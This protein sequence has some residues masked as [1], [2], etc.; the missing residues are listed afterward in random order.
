LE[1]QLQQIPEIEE[2]AI[3]ASLFDF[4]GASPETYDW[5]ERPQDVEPI[6]MKHILFKE[7]VGKLYEFKLVAGE[8]LNE[9]DSKDCIMI[10][11]S[12]AKI[13]GWKDPAGKQLV[14]VNRYFP[15][16]PDYRNYIVKGVIKDIHC[17]SF[18]GPADPIIFR[19]KSLP[20]AESVLFRY[21]EGTWNTCKDKIEQLF[22][23]KY[24]D[25]N[26]LSVRKEEFNYAKYLKSENTLL[27][28]L[29]LISLVCLTVC[30][31]GFVS[32][33]SLTCE[34]RRKEIAIR[35]INGATIKDILDIFFK[36]YLTLFI[37]GA[38]IA[39]PAGYVIMKRWIEGYALQTEMSAWIY[40]S[41]LVILTLT[42]VLCV[43]GKVYKTSCE[44][45][46]EAIN[47]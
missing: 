5:N 42:I 37:V 16:N 19:H 23:E 8:M 20:P 3:G 45:P 30:V 6:K 25:I 41:I 34:E 36:E 15:D 2:T 27:T 38:L 46:V 14:G 35:K 26:G 7:K 12:A 21:R 29:T 32:M 44:N 22:K 39:F 40:I 11:E 33:V 1:N 28:I 9:N 18:T 17:S 24:P 43:G 31:F 4:Y 47:S 10:N 13:F